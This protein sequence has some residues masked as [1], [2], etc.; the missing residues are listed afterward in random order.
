MLQ[1]DPP[2]EHVQA[3]RS[4]YKSQIGTTTAPSPID[5]VQVDCHLD[6]ITQKDVVLWDDIQQLFDG[7]LHIRHKSRMVPFL[8]DADLA[9][10]GFK[11]DRPMEV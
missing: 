11:Y 10:Y 6:P 4:V 5:I 2:Q 8:K 7:A 1:G 3:V 9:T